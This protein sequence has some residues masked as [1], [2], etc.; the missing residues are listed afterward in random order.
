MLYGKT[1]RGMN[2][3]DDQGRTRAVSGVRETRRFTGAW[4]L[5]SET[6]AG[7]CV[8][9]IARRSCSARD[10]HWHSL[11]THCLAQP[12]LKPTRSFHN[13]S[14]RTTPM[15]ARPK[16]LK[17]MIGR[18]DEWS[19]VSDRWIDSGGTRKSGRKRGNHIPRIRRGEWTHENS[20]GC[21]EP[22]SR[23]VGY[24]ALT[25]TRVK[26]WR[27]KYL[28]LG[29]WCTGCDQQIQLRLRGLGDDFVWK[30]GYY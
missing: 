5:C 21:D 27:L 17:A 24:E 18:C 26:N 4:I 30:F 19:R 1:K 25:I 20:M 2:W 29:D 11:L 22:N 16:T 3:N 8:S 13:R 6:R 15:A 23:R 14:R 7:T 28:N 12:P 9:W 10:A